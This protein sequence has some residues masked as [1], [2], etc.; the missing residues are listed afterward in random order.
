VDVIEARINESLGLDVSNL[1]IPVWIDEIRCEPG[2]LTALGRAR[3]S[4]PPS[5]AIAA[6]KPEA[7]PAI[8]AS[9]VAD[10][11]QPA[12]VPPLPTEASA[13][14]DAAAGN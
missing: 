1:S 7:E 3:I 8:T 11:Q 5:A 9:T 14:D 12:S 4:W 13:I 2:R 10:E 6:A